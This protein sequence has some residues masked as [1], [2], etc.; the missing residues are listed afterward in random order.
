A[1][2]AALLPP[3]VRLW[4]DP[5]PELRE[6]TDPGAYA[7]PAPDARGPADRDL[8]GAHSQGQRAGAGT[9]RSRVADRRDGPGLPR[10]A[11]DVRPRCQPG[12][13]GGAVRGGPDRER[14]S[15]RSL[16]AQP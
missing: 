8:R 14:C 12:R 1:G 4:A 9:G 5:D 13:R 11:P 15:K 3:R 16:L 7:P 2:P 10:G 6:V